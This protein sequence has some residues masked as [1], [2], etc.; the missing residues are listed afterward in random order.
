MKEAQVVWGLPELM[1][2]IPS[3]SAPLPRS[4]SLAFSWNQS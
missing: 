4:P 2:L 3:A 1:W